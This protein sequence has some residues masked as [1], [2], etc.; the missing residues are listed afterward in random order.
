MYPSMYKTIIYII[1]FSNCHTIILLLYDYLKTLKHFSVLVHMTNY[2]LYNLC[3]FIQIL[4][5]FYEQF[6]VDNSRFR[7]AT[8]KALISTFH[9]I[10][11]YPSVQ[12]LL[13][14]PAYRWTMFVISK[15]LCRGRY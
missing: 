7:L 13:G 14:G 15:M 9:R 5:L 1:M 2:C 10:M 4:K 11:L 3:N 12:T 8:K 6:N